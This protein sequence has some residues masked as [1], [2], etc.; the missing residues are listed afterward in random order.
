[1]TIHDLR[2]VLRDFDGWLADDTSGIYDED[3]AAWCVDRLFPD[4]PDDKKARIADI[5]LDERGWD[6]WWDGEEEYVQRLWDWD[7][8][9][10]FSRILSRIERVLP[11]D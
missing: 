7:L 2:R 5:F 9:S 11:S 4:I 3:R 10:E 8:D 1:M 6:E